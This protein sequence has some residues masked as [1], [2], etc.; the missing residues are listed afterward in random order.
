[1]NLDKF[2]QLEKA[3]LSYLKHRG[4]ILEISRELELPI[5]YVQ[6]LVSKFRKQE[7]RNVSVLISHTLMSHILHGTQSRTV[8]LMEMLG[9]L[10]QTEKPFLSVCCHAPFRIKKDGKNECLK[11]FANCEIV[12]VPKTSIYTIKKD[13]IEQLREEDR[14]LVEMAG[15]M[16]Y[17][18][19]MEPPTTIIQNKQNVLMIGGDNPNATP[20]LMSEL[21]NLPPMEKEKL[22]EKLR[23]EIINLDEELQHT[24]DREKETLSPN[25]LS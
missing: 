20:K 17:T 6:K 14:T 1:M 7:D 10:A 22:V 18:N 3:K 5:E 2:K 24:K 9:S 13:I 23:K 12:E 21:N 19:K 8:H 15:K 4:N 25:P 11:C 16:G